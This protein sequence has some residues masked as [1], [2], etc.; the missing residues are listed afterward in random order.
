MPWAYDSGACLQEIIPALKKGFHVFGKG[1]K[2]GPKISREVICRQITQKG[3]AA[4]QKN[5][6]TVGRMAWCWNG[7][8]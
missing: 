3:L 7:F 4:G 1:R 8:A 2:Y 5:G 6:Q